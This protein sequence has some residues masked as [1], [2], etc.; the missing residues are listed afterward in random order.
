MSFEDSN[1]DN[2][3]TKIAKARDFGKLLKNNNQTVVL[4]YKGKP[5]MKFGKEANP[6]LSLLATFSRDVEVTNLSELRR[7]GKNLNSGK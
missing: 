4:C 3:F 7:L 6:K 5:V 2:I 1:G